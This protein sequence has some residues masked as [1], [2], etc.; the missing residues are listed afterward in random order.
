MASNDPIADV[1]KTALV[2]GAVLVAGLIIIGGFLIPQIGRSR[3][4][5][6]Q[7]FALSNARRL[8]NALIHYANEHGQLPD[9]KV[10]ATGA[11]APGLSPKDFEWNPWDVE[12][13]A[14]NDN[15]AGKPLPTGAASRQI[16]IFPSHADYP[17][18][19][20][21]PREVL[22]DEPCFAYVTGEAECLDLTMYQ[23][24]VR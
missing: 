7:G 12:T 21:P 20:M 16:L 13:F 23:N 2:L 24:L 14:L 3:K 15:L 17:Y 4:E 11:F 19:V 6:A 18:L 1:K 8:A 9:K 5:S 22:G 10:Y